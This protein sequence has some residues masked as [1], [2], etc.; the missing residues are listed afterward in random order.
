MPDIALRFNKDML[1][2]SAPVD[3][4]LARQGVNVDEDMEY[5]LLMEPE[6]IHDALQMENA[7]GAQCLVLPTSGFTAARLAHK[8]MEDRAAD[9]VDSVCEAVSSVRAQHIMI[10]I[11]QCGLPLD[12]S[13]K[14]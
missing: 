10:E 13:S 4:I 2:L 9:L 14:A 3:N 1:V 8:R 5:Q 11:G 12:T 7:A 6:S